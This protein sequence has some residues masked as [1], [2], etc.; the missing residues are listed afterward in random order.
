MAIELINEFKSTS[1]AKKSKVRGETKTSLTTFYN[2][3]ARFSPIHIDIVG[4]STTASDAHIYLFSSTNLHIYTQLFSTK[5]RINRVR[6]NTQY[7][8][9][10]IITTHRG[11]FIFI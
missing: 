8:D 5:G 7:G 6:W 10:D 11:T 3:D 1:F 2:P 9:P 4:P